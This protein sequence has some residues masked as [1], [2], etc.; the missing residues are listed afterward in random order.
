MSHFGSTLGRKAAWDGDV[1]GVSDEDLA[2][3]GLDT[4]SGLGNLLGGFGQVTCPQPPQL[5]VWL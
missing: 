2:D 4:L 5:T 3:P 1:V